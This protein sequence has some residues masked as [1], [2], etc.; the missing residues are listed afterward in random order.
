M[1]FK[2]ILKYGFYKKSL[3]KD[4]FLQ[5]PYFSDLHSQFQNAFIYLLL[6]CFNQTLVLLSYEFTE[7]STLTDSEID[8]QGRRFSE[9]FSDFDKE[10]KQMEIDAIK[11]ELDVSL[12]TTSLI[13]MLLH[14]KASELYR[15]LGAPKLMSE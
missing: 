4:D 8:S 5:N 12:D 9:V 6:N 15:S 14:K 2:D 11:K 1:N 7:A 13:S 3:R 10:L